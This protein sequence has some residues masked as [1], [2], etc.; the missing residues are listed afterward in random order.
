M[1]RINAKPHPHQLIKHAKISY[2]FLISYVFLTFTCI[3]QIFEV[4]GVSQK[5]RNVLVLYLL[6]GIHILVYSCTRCS[7][8]KIYLCLKEQ[9]IIFLGEFKIRN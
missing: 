6:S 9:I 2:A 8:L 7:T 4:L 5:V 1:L 3:L